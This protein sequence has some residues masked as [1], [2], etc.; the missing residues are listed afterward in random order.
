MSGFFKQ[1]FVSAMM[2]FGCNVSSVNS[3][4]CISMNNQECKIRPEIININ[5]N[6][7][8]FYPYSIKVN[9]CSGSC[10][11][12]NDPYAKFCVL[13]IVKNMNV[14]VFNLMSRTNEKRHMK[15]HETFK[16][17]LRLDISVCNHKQRWNNDKCRC[18]CK[19]LIDKG[20][21]DTGFIWNP[22]NCECQ[23]DKSCDVGEY[24]DYANCKCIKRLIDKI[25]EECSEGI[26]EVKMTI[27]SLA[28]DESK[29]KSSCTIYVFLITIIFTIC[30]GVGTYFIY[31]KYINHDKET[32]TRYDY[33]YQ[34][35]L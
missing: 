7:P 34:A 19:E 24:L 29:C 25:V 33:V 1:T 26:N 21:C 13:D 2:F 15:W 5:S 31:Y 12:I 23:Y 32:A 17:K 6:E 8:L 20:I 30:I 18:E 11:S 3:S 10:N 28:E 27:I 4:K 35:T 22:S 14:K 9:N 16:R